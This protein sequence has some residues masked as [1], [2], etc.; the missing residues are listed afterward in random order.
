MRVS[1]RW[2]RELL[3]G[4]KASASDVS[5]RLTHAGLEVEA[6]M[7][8]GHGL[9]PVVVAEVKSIEAH[10]KRSGLRLVLVDRGNG[11]QRVVCGASN[12]PDPGGLVVLA[13]LGTVLPE[14]GELTARDIGGVTS[15]GMLVSESE[16]GLADESEG[17]IVLP[18]GSA[19]PGTPFLEACPAARDT[20]FEIGITP[21]RPDALGHVGV[22]R[23]LAALFD[24]R[25]EPPAPPEAKSAEGD[26]TALVQVENEDTER[27][28]H[29]G[30][31]AVV[32]VSI[33]PSPDWLRWRLHTLGVRP[34]SNVVDITNLLLLGF[35]QPMHAFDLDRVR[36]QKIVVRRARAGEPFTT[37]D[38][39]KRS[40][41]A[42]DLVICDGEGPSALAGVMGGEDSEI[43]DTT[44]RVL[45][46]CAYFQPRGV[47]RT[48]RRHALHTES[49]YR[50]ERGVD[51]GAIPT[52]L[53]H[54]K[55]WLS[56]LCGGR[57]VPGTIHAKG[58]APELPRIRLRS[59]RLDALLGAHVPFSD[60]MALLG[61]LGF[62]ETDRGEDADGDRH[63][64]VTAVSWRPDIRREVDL[65]EEVARVHGLDRIP[66]VLPAIAPQPPRTSGALE[67]T[68]A[69]EAV[70]LGLS[71]A[72]TYAFVSP[73]E[74]SAISAPQPVVSLKNPLTEERSVMR[75]SLLPGLL[76]ALKRARRRGE[77]AVRLFT[78]GACFLPPSTAERSAA[79][80]A[81]RPRGAGDHE[82]P[83]ERP[84]FAAVL[85]GP[86]PA[87]LS[88]PVAHD[89]WDAKGLAQELTERL[90]GRSASV[91]LAA[92]A[93]KH[94][95]PRGAGEVLVQGRVAGRFGPLHPDVVDAL[96]LDGDAFV[97][98]LFLAEIEALGKATP[99]FS[100]IPRLPA[101]TRDIAL[102]VKDEV[103]AEAVQQVIA[104]AAGE[105]CESVELFDLFRGGSVPEGHRSLAFH[106]VYRDPKA[107]T[108]PDAARTLTD[109]EVDQ[110]HAKVEKAATEKL[111]GALRV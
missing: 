99:K 71:E 70:S 97:V 6:V 87:Y 72:V 81:A 66:T 93:P 95:H 3:P 61:R 52:V 43:R 28:P 69:R 108:D 11:E 86:R 45:L 92:D 16:L 53:E 82:L 39:V 67:R 17:I 2:I 62:E 75:T 37:L 36:G 111:G 9:E 19:K 110:R 50:F 49:S 103:A 91:R 80:E 47:R 76:E 58:P 68:I 105:L 13:P 38:G 79:A 10:P 8:I 64:T 27:C 31:A 90:T 73:A 56:E 32:D 57:V 14:I 7:E 83:E 88:Q 29:Y 30:A 15:E 41:D 59:S 65:I 24:V 60:A 78:V 35:G 33:G 22:A 101:V 4:L 96:D 46:E 21:N 63:A 34:I 77:R 104:E 85:A 48:A 107:A 23:E 26:V 20:L 100:P 106:L 54:A 40:L 109:K 98:E 1:L 42:D 44:R 89:V 84:Y 94:L 102:V 55:G 18:P 74:L 12:V 51:F 25:F 5:E